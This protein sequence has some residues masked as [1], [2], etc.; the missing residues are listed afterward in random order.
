MTL[1]HARAFSGCGFLAELKH[2]SASQHAWLLPFTTLLAA[3]HNPACCQETRQST[4]VGLLLA[5]EP[6]VGAAHS[7]TVQLGAGEPHHVSHSDSPLHGA[8]LALPL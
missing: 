7:V 4:T 5:G 1:A 6:A 8:C 2:L 3:F